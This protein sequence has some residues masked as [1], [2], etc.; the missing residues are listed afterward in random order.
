MFFF[1]PRVIYYL[2]T[3]HGF[4]E[5]S[6]LLTQQTPLLSPLVSR[7]FVLPIY[8][9]CIYCCVVDNIVKLALDHSSARFYY[10]NK[11]RINL[12][13]P[14]VVWLQK[15]AIEE[16]SSDKSSADKS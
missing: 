16:T 14:V 7:L 15:R 3:R 5:M 8:V 4:R 1:L 6:V 10:R 13:V 12:H 2:H 11:R 9:K